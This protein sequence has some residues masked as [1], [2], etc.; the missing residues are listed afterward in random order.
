[1]IEF[2]LC[3]LLFLG[4]VLGFAQ[5][6][7][8]VWTKSALQ[9]AVREGVRYAVTGATSGGRGH[10]GSIRDAVAESSGGLIS[11]QQADSQVQVQFYD[12]DANQTASNAGGNIVVVRVADYPVPVMVPAILAFVPEGLQVSANAVDRLEPFGNP[13]T[14]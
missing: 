5:M 2:S 10:L 9:H 11:T 6:A 12:E 3:F 4:T 7:M 14:L 13:P 1:M 8:V